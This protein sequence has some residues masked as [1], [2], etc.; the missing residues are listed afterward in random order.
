MIPIVIILAVIL[1]VN[2]GKTRE[3][4]CPPPV[5]CPEPE[6]C[7][8]CLGVPFA[9]LDELKMAIRDIGSA[10]K[11]A[12]YGPSS[13]WDVSKIEYLDDV[14]Q[15]LPTSRGGYSDDTREGLKR[16]DGPFVKQLDI[17]NWNTKGVKSMRGMF[18]P[19]G[20]PK[21]NQD[22]SGWD[23]STVEDMSLMFYEAKS[24]N[25]PLEEW[26]VSS[27]KNMHGMFYGAT[28]FNQ[29]LSG[30]D[31]G[32][33]TDMKI[34]FMNARSFRGPIVN[35]SIKSLRDRSDTNSMFDLDKDPDTDETKWVTITDGDNPTLSFIMD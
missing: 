13:H 7:E 25:H 5:V 10:D 6:E 35:W 14:F 23:V 27:V 26:D 11:L 28:S 9:T 20:F 32:K 12:P 16:D 31:T 15:Y 3:P 8:V 33:V 1:Y 4:E 30:W 17:S 22:I 21:F 24:F 34:M 2:I 29:P 18:K 19:T